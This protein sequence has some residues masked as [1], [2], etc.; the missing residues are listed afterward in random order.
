MWHEM[1]RWQALA[2][3][4]E[5]TRWQVMTR[6]HEIIWLQDKPWVYAHLLDIQRRIGADHFPLI[7]QTSSGPH[8]HGKL[9]PKNQYLCFCWGG[10][11]SFAF[12]NCDQYEGVMIGN[13]SNIKNA[14]KIG[15]S[16]VVYS[17]HQNLKAPQ[18]ENWKEIIFSKIFR[19]LL[20][21]RV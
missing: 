17:Q 3:W 10:Y 2:I 1:I 18:H 21:R 5:L 20:C 7:P 4:Y 14:S 13:E 19:M 6:R 11:L 12:L 9:W 8:T 16:R 15:C